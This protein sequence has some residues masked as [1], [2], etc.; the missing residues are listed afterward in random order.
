MIIHPRI[1]AV[2]DDPLVIELIKDILA[3]DYRVQATTDPHEALALLDREEFDLLV[4]D[5]GIPEIDGTEIVRHVRSHP[6][7]RTLPIVVVSAYIELAR[8]VADLDVQA[9]IRKPFQLDQ[10]YATLDKV[11]AES[12]AKSGHL[13]NDL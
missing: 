11:L 7:S 13:A 8:R 10:L 5:L 3:Q 9:I 2:D 6:H 4:V 1:L 12:R